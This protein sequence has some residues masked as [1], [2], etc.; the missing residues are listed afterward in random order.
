MVDKMTWPRTQ[1]P[2]PV[3]YLSSLH[4]QN[5]SIKAKSLPLHN[6]SG[7]DGHKCCDGGFHTTTNLLTAISILHNCHMPHHLRFSILEGNSISTQVST[8]R[9]LLTDWGNISAFDDGGVTKCRHQPQQMT[10][11]M[12]HNMR[13]LNSTLAAVVATKKISQWRPLALHLSHPSAR[14]VVDGPWISN[15]DPQRVSNWPIENQIDI[16]HWSIHRMSFGG[17][18]IH[19]RWDGIKFDCNLITFIP[20]KEF[21]HRFLI[22]FVSIC[23]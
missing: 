22:G 13:L 14:C 7:D 1:K 15:Y 10:K 17:C 9:L 16:R 11:S 4:T 8:L 2:T 20:R 3:I 5:P 23:V 6:S 19:W 21:V 12:S 18:D